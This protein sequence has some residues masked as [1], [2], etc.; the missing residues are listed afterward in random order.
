MARR[1][2]GPA[3]LQVVQAVRGLVD[4]VASASGAPHADRVASASERVEIPTLVLGV[5]GGADSMAL[6]AGL[7]ATLEQR[8][9]A[10]LGIPDVLAVV[11]DHGL[12]PGSDE[13]ASTVAARVEA[14]GLACRVVRVEVATD[15]G[16]GLEAAARGAR[17]AALREAAG[18]G[19]VVLGH[20]LDDQGETVLLGLARGSGTRSLAG[21]AERA[22]DLV[23]P[24]LGLPRTATVQACREWGI[25]VWDDPHNTD[26][27]FL[28]S[29]VRHELMPV[30]N[31]VLGPGVAKALARTATLAAQDA[32]ALDVWAADHLPDGDVLPVATLEALPPAVASR[33]LRAWLLACGATEV[34]H[35]HTAS[36]LALVTHW[37][38]QGPISL[39][40]LFVQRSDGGLLASPSSVR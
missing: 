13:V 29:R 18:G 17:L 5:S 12:Q 37:R 24:L 19:L 21:I 9:R 31:E 1:E 22:G 40:G 34:N 11:V 16:M 10:G 35:D 33:V 2:L 27:R 28:R 23:R 14:L 20:T 39:P 26:P 38:G 4:D 15:S 30:L 32:D 25:D 3:A 7:A 6:A 36:A 8:R